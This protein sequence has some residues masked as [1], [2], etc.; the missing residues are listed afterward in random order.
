VRLEGRR[1]EEVNRATESFLVHARNIFELFFKEP[2][3]GR[4]DVSF[5]HFLDDWEDGEGWQPVAAVSCPYLHHNRTRLNRALAHLSYARITEP[6]KEWDIQAIMREL[7]SV[8]REFLGQLPER[9]HWF[10][11]PP[12]AGERHPPLAAMCA[13]GEEDY[14]ATG[15][16]W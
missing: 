14:P 1:R 13:E 16:G 11:P 15:A 7:A 12:H 5:R 4:P 6:E 9:Q 10:A 2:Q 3:E 8:C